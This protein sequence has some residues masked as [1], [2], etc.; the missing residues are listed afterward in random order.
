MQKDE[1]KIGTRFNYLEVI[2]EPFPDKK[3]WRTLWKCKCKCDC[4]NEYI[5][6]CSTIIHNKIKSCGCYRKIASKK[7]A[8]E[9]N[10]YSAEL[11]SHPLYGCYKGMTNACTAIKNREDCLKKIKICEEWFHNY[12]AFYDWAIKTWEK[13][14]IL[15]RKDREEGFNPDNCIFVLPKDNIKYSN[16]EKSKNTM[17]ERYGGW[18][19]STTEHKEKTKKTCLEKYGCEYV[20]QTEESKAKKRATCLEKYGY[21]Y[22]SSHPDV[23]EKIRL[24]MRERYGV[25]VAS[26][27][28]DISAKQMKTCMERYGR[29]NGGKSN[30]GEQS[31]LQQWLNNNTF[32]TN[33]SYE[34]IKYRE[35][36]LY[37]EELKF[38]IEYCGLYWHCENK[39]GKDLHRF[40]FQEC[41]KKDIKLLTIFSDDWKYREKQTKS[42]ILS[43]LNKY[44]RT[45]DI[46]DCRILI[47]DNAVIDG[48]LNKNH[49]K[50]SELDT[51][52][53]IGIYYEGYLVSAASFYI[54]NKAL[55][56]DR[57][58]C[59]CN[60]N[61]IDCFDKI[62]E[63]S[64]E[65]CDKNNLNKIIA[66]SDNCYTN[67]E[68]YIGA[69]FS[70]DSDI[71]PDYKY[72]KLSNSNK[73][74]DKSKI[75]LP[76][77][78]TDTGYDRVWDCGKK[79]FILNV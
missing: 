36:D 53:N 69:G 7:R 65:Y 22:S 57:Y 29:L 55:I 16:R 11:I 15:S 78:L 75:S 70:F 43:L 54:D 71:E 27:N 5:A 62:I 41:E 1:C 63:L 9:Q 3:G 47:V 73:R 39:R 72:I 31:K 58:A 49:I 44:E 24:T 28:P 26:Q 6:I 52:F 8:S 23:I 17:Y 68:L 14:L 4:G 79:K 35:I 10:K 61:V 45:V 37:S 34:V 18:Y 67:E 13:G 38:G 60:N 51:I 40:K 76:D 56:L 21:E 32:I 12:I 50:Y 64:Q 2:E 20:S 59:L 33:S 46:K 25:D 66:I 19:A 74:I 77:D 42:F 30:L 48:F